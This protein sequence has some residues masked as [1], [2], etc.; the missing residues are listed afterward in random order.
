MICYSQQLPSSFCFVLIYINQENQ[1]KLILLSIWPS[2]GWVGCSCCFIFLDMS[3]WDFL[4]FVFYKVIFDT[5]LKLADLALDK[6]QKEEDEFL[7]NSKTYKVKRKTA[8]PNKS[9]SNSPTKSQAIES[10]TRSPIKTK[11]PQHVSTENVSQTWN[12]HLQ[13]KGC[14]Y[15][16]NDNIISHQYSLMVRKKSHHRVLVQVQIYFRNEKIG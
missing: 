7:V 1:F 6:L 13:S 12:C 11:S 2:V 3:F 14:F 4:I 10:P 16:E 9:L 5:S 15:F 8:S